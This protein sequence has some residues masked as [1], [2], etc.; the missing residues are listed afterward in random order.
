MPSINGTMTL[1]GQKEDVDVNP[2]DIVDEL[3]KDLQLAVMADL[4]LLKDRLGLF[5][6]PFFIDVRAE[7]NKTILPGT[8][9]E[10]D[11][12]AD[13]TMEMLI[14]G[15]GVNYRLGPYELRKGARTGMPRLIVEPYLGGR[16]S[17]IDVKLDIM[18]T[19]SRSFH[20]NVGWADPMFGARAIWELNPHWNIMVGG[21][22][23]GFGVGSDLAW[24]VTG[25]VG[26]RFHIT[27]RAWEQWCGGIVPCTRTTREA[28]GPTNLSMT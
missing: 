26:W 3:L 4:E 17:D 10:E 19:R 9:L 1:S 22:V 6:N 24:S 5:V 21:D 23:G 27:K 8:I 12:K 13:V 14:M 28:V 11:I 2:L 7:E 18:A 25:L 15:F 16:W 20:D